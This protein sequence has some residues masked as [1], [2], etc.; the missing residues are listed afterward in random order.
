M[1]LALATT[2]FIAIGSAA[3]AQSLA[4][5][6]GSLLGASG[7]GSEFDEL[8][9]LV[10]ESIGYVNVGPG[11][12]LIESEEPAGSHICRIDIPDEFFA[13]YLADDAEMRIQNRP[14][15]AC[16]KIADLGR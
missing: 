2:A 13:G 14:A 7:L 3:S 6:V 5:I 16:V 11:L 10:D 12:V 8:N 4:D 9:T 15:V 1:K